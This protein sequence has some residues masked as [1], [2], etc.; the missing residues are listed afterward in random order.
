V[1]RPTDLL[2]A[3]ASLEGAH[4]IHIDPAA[5]F[6]QLDARH[7]AAARRGA[8]WQDVWRSG[9]RPV[10]GDQCR[11]LSLVRELSRSVI[12]VALV[13]VHDGRASPN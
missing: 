3:F 9:E 7:P 6:A 11:A 2:E 1:H 4:L 10:I 5:G 8:L 12:T 13:T